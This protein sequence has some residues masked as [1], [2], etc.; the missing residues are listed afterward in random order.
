MHLLFITAAFGTLAV[1]LYRRWRGRHRLPLPPGPKRLPLVGN[2]LD[3][4]YDG[5]HAWHVYNDWASRF[6]DIT[7]IEVFGS[8]MVILTMSKPRRSCWR[9]D[10]RITRI[11][12][13]GS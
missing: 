4:S 6:G 8:P 9:N 12:L 13:V 1:I 10:L 7:Y 5:K 2:I 3:I 11:D